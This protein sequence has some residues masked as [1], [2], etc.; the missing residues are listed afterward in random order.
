MLETLHLSPLPSLGIAKNMKGSPVPDN[1]ERQ[2]WR[3]RE[4]PAAT[5]NAL[6]RPP[7]GSNLQSLLVFHR[8]T[9][10]D[11]LLSDSS[12]S[13]AQW[14]CS[15]ATAHDIGSRHLGDTTMTQIGDHLREMCDSSY[16]SLLIADGCRT[17]A[18][19]S[20]C[21]RGIFREHHRKTRKEGPCPLACGLRHRFT[22][23]L[24][25][26]ETICRAR[27]TICPMRRAAGT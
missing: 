24:L 10:P 18:S 21:T 5:L 22:G 19:V 12:R 14:L 16:F 9:Y 4:L 8:M 1:V 7:R 13:A 11:S 6:L 15:P 23:P 27:A 25:S 2:L 17:P 20:V 3:R 26:R